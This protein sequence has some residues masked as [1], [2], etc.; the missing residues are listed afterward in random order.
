MR[1]ALAELLLATVMG[2]D[3]RDVARQRPILQALA[4]LKYDEYQQFSPG[5]RFVESLAFWLE[6][7][8]PADRPNAYDFI[9]SKLVFFSEAEFS[10]F[11]SVIYPDY[12]RPILLE[13]AATDEGLPPHRVSRTL[14]GAAFRK[15]LESTLFLGL[16]D[17][18]RLDHFRRS[19]R[20]L[21]HERVFQTAELPPG[22]LDELHRRLA[23]DTP[24][25]KPPVRA[26]VLLDDFAGSGKTYA[27]WDEEE[28]DYDGKVVRLLNHLRTEE[29]W[30]RLAWFPD[31]LIVIALYVS[32][33]RALQHMKQALG[34]YLRGVTDNIHYVCVQTLGDTYCLGPDSPDPFTVLIE[35]HYDPTVENE[36]TRKGGTDLKFG[37]SGCGLPVV[38]HHNTP[39]NSIF[40]LWAE[41]SDVV[42]PLFPRVSRHKGES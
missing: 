23:P 34:G 7:F 13:R 31:T 20:E 40:L 30:K 37:F 2:W 15:L 5:M 26:L 16:S 9:A 38:L 6:Q 1:D 25:G 39:N 8:V 12:V 24:D 21:D 11:V 32:T 27:R 36:H 17:G 28:A 3:Q 10:H 14:R 42:R 29:S 22:K 33:T 18:A 19:N 41:G 4:E 35:N